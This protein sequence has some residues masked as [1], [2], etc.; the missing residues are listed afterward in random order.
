MYQ[1]AGRRPT[2][3]LA[4]IV[5]VVSGLAVLALRLEPGDVAAA[6]TSTTIAPSTTAARA[7]RATTS[8]TRPAPTTAAPATTE[9]GPPPRASRRVAAAVD[10]EKIRPTSMPF[11][12]MGIATGILIGGLAIAGFVYGKVRSRPP[13]P[14]ASRPAG[15][16]TG[17]PA[18]DATPS[19]VPSETMPPPTPLPPPQR[20]TDAVSDWAPPTP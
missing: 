15:V 16:A 8:T 20:P 6:P 11:R 12:T 14:A 3:A 9:A 4:L 18:T 5:I 19:G 10:I 17:P 1:G 13:V 7:T 2:S